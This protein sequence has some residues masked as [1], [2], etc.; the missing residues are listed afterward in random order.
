MVGTRTARVGLSIDRFRLDCNEMVFED[1]RTFCYL[2]EQFAALR[3]QMPSFDHRSSHGA[4]PGRASGR[5]TARADSPLESMGNAQGSVEMAH[6]EVILGSRV[7]RL[8]F[9]ER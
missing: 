1:G 6:F 3:V 9:V 7:A 5:T 8:Q 2:D 4:F